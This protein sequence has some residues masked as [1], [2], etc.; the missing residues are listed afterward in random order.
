MKKNCVLLL[1]IVLLSLTICSLTIGMA[2]A[3][4]I[5]E[6]EEI[7]EVEQVEEEVALVET[8]S[9]SSWIKAFWEKYGND[10]NNALSGISIGSIVT[11]VVVAIIRKETAKV[12]NKVEDKQTKIDIANGVI[13][14]IKDT[15]IGV[16]IMPIV[17]SEIIKL[18]EISNAHNE[19]REKLQ[20]ERY[21]A[22]IRLLECQAEY[23]NNS[24]GVADD[25]KQNM[26]DALCAAKEL[27]K[28]LPKEIPAVI[29][30]EL[31]EEKEETTIV[32]M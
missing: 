30:V 11:A 29:E 2:F 1:L 23:F 25:A 31:K 17:K 4:E 28:V 14:G 22:I 15:K 13:D 24:V 3:E 32:E 7:V 26:Q 20:D 12:A 18:G 27:V 16:S 6:V 19:K 8:N 5:K 10:V 9:F 21:A